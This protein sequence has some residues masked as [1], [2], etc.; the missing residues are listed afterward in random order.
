MDEPSALCVKEI[1]FFLL[2]TTLALVFLGPAI[3]FVCRMGWSQHEQPY[4]N[5]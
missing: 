5:N 2:D 3:L 4:P 1:L